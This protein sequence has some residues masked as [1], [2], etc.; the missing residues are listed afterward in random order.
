MGGKILL[1]EEHGTSLAE[2]EEKKKIV[3]YGT[4]GAVFVGGDCKKGIV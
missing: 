1:C 2:R 4:M 3:L